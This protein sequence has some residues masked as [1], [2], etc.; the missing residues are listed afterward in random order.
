MNDEELRQ[1]F[2]TVRR[3]NA[4]AHD[5]TR[6]L[7]REESAAGHGET[8]RIL[9]E[10]STVAHAETRRILRDEITQGDAETRR[11]TKVLF[12]AT[13]HDIQLVAEAVAI[14]DEKLDRTATAIRTE[15]RTG[16][17]ETHAM[18]TGL[19]RRLTAVERALNN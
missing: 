2:D 3:E 6:R 15:M 19:D 1:L 18:I 13:Q 8:R 10:E 11:Y 9:R 17:D 14:L 7:I 5:E 12:E 16:F 4:A